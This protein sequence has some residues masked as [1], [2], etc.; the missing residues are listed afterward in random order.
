MTELEKLDAGL[1]YSFW[2]AEV[3]A[4][5][6]RAIEKC[7][8]LNALPQSDEAAREPYI[9]DLFAEVGADPSIGT[10]FNC[11]YGLNI[12]VGDNF[13]TNYNVTIL[14]IAPVRI[15][16]DVMIGPNTII[17]TVGHP[18][19]PKGRRE[20]LGVC[21]PVTIGS[22][23][24]IGGNV[25][26]LPGVTIGSNVVVGA[27]AVVTRDVPDNVVVGGVPARVIRSIENDVE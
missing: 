12:R 13:L 18:L 9:R 20:H 3:N 23:V 26:I 25:T 5:K 22:D 27:G 2:D 24:W 19:S 1:P 8:I 21:K 11:D 14:D 6:L 15:G 4:R 17:T 7:G 16:N 10:G